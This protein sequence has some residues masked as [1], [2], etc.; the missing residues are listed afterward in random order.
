MKIIIVIEFTLQ[1]NSIFFYINNIYFKF[2]NISVYNNIK[3]V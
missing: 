3:L 2:N 1:I